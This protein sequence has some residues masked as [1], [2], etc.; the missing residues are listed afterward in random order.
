MGYLHH[1]RDNKIVRNT[2]WR[3]EKNKTSLNKDH[4]TFQQNTSKRIANSRTL[5]MPYGPFTWEQE[6]GAARTNVQFSALSLEVLEDFL[7][8]Y[9]GY[10]NT[11]II[12]WRLGR[13]SIPYM[14]KLRDVRIN[15]RAPTKKMTRKLTLQGRIDDVGEIVNFMRKFLRR[16]LFNGNHPRR[17]VTRIKNAQIYDQKEDHPKQ[18]PSQSYN[19]EARWNSNS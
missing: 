10:G 13:P 9:G 18:E 1:Q 6:L 17:E 2:P 16:K 19:E 4:L 12:S 11:E 15:S 8:Q 5:K 7:R 14:I 3:K